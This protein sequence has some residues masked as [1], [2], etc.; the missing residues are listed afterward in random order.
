MTYN[1]KNLILY[2]IIA[3]AIGGLVTGYTIWNKP[4]KD[5][6]DAKAIPVSAV[7][8]Y[9]VYVADSAK[10]KHMYE[11]KIL[12]V[13]GEIKQV[14]LN[15]Q[16]QQIIL[17]KTATEGAAVNCTM[18]QND[19]NAK[20]GN[21]ISLKGICSGYIGGDADMGLPGNVFIVRCYYVNQ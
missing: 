21:K 16:N 19:P 20:A 7:N 17:L 2:I 4:H 5:V 1:S 12:W 8:L 6:K 9:N 15:Q 14:S 3:I 10:A 18:E 11:N 13:T